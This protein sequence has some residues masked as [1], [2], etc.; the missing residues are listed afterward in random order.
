[1]RARSQL[2]QRVNI[3]RMNM[4]LSA[5]VAPLRPMLAGHR[6]ILQA[7]HAVDI[8]QW[9]TADQRERTAGSRVQFCH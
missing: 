5:R 7:D 3:D 4:N 9:T 1:L 2:G 8:S 6:Q